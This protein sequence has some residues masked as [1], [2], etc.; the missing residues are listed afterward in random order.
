MTAWEYDFWSMPLVSKEG[1][2]R[3]EYDPG[4]GLPVSEV[5]GAESA[6]ARIQAELATELA[7]RGSLG[8]ELA[9]SHLIPNLFNAVVPGALLFVFKRPRSD[10]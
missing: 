1:L 3:Q 2:Q 5:Q 9:A 6:Y 7:R 4:T 8:W 10:A